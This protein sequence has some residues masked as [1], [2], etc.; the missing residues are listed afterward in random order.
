MSG[1]AIPHIQTPLSIFRVWIR[2]RCLL[3]PAERSENLDYGYILDVSPARIPSLR[4]TLCLSFSWRIL[5]MQ[6]DDRF[7]ILPLSFPVY[8]DSEIVTGEKSEVAV[9]YLLLH[10]N[11]MD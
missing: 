6:W 3:Y 2:S 9:I 11:L 10:A 4:D 7:D 1:D 8:E 5:G